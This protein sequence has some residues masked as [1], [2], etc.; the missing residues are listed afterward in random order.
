MPSTPKIDPTQTPN[1]ANQAGCN[2]IPSVADFALEV[3]HHFKVPSTQQWNLTVQRDLG[4]QWVLE[5]G[6]VGT[7]A[8]HLRET[9]DGIQSVNASAANPF[10]VTDVNGISYQI[11]HS[12]HALQCGCTHAN[13]GAQRLRG[14][15]A[16]RQRCLFSLP[17]FAGNAI[18][19]LERRLFAGGIYLLQIHGFHFHRQHRFQHRL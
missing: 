16:F 5:V 18:A 14:I 1:Y 12:Q 7:H 13:T 17:L 3:P 8:I 19:A 11:D 15:P 4:K 6:Y 10:T 2:G 9:R